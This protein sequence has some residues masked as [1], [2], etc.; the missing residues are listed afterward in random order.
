MVVLSIQEQLKRIDALQDDIDQLDKRLASL[1]KKN[2]QMQPVITEK[3][4]SLLQT[5]VIQRT[6]K[7]A[8]P[9][10]HSPRPCLEA[11]TAG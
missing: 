4:F 8:K 11:R 1:V 9:C 7:F 6:V 5:K 2:K 3:L 10:M